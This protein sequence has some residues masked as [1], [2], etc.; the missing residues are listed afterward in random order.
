[1]SARSVRT[2]VREL[3]TRQQLSTEYFKA[4]L[5]KAFPVDQ[6]APVIEV[7]TPVLNP[8]VSPALGNTQLELD[9]QLELTNDGETIDTNLHARWF[10]F[11]PTLEKYFPLTRA[12]AES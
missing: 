10:D 6:P 9:M 12:Y 11:L 7:A 5:G 2:H 3:Q 4:G 1:V 8:A